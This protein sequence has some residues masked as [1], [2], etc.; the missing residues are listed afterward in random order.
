MTPIA[1][2]HSRFSFWLVI[3]FLGL[4]WATPG[5]AAT[6][7]AFGV[8]RSANDGRSWVKV[9]QGL[10]SG[11]RIDA[12]GG[13][14]NVRFAGTERGVFISADDGDTWTRP[15]RGVPE[16]LK[17]FAFAEFAGHIY[18]AS[19]QGLWASADRGDSWSNAAAPLAG[20]R[21]LSVV[22]NGDT[23]FAGTDGQGVLVTR[24]HG[25]TWESIGAG[26]P[27]RAQIFQFAVQNGAV[28]AALY[29]RGVYRYDSAAAK[30]ISAGDEQPL[31]LVAFDS[32][33][34]SGRN[35]GGVFTLAAGATTWV[36]TSRGLPPDA[37]T[38]SLASTPNTVLIG[39]NGLAGVMRWD[40]ATS[41]WL[42]ATAG[43]PRDGQA[44]AFGVGEK[45]ILAT[46]IHQP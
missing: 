24:D 37:P 9:G 28:F 30:W 39:T 11:L 31:C 33:L 18:A 45:T 36:E 1:I 3:G 5:H 32:R 17:I 22:A 23:L 12:L 4:A 29:A 42:P 34:F 43:L 13:R 16:T 6:A 25:R 46:I 20:T 10:P 7:Q 2:P 27:P 26:L 19:S 14:N 38:W 44:I 8:Y 41:S 15:T 21:I 35:P 40:R